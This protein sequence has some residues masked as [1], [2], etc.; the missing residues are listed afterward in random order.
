[1]LKLIGKNLLQLHAIQQI[2]TNGIFSFS[3]P[4]YSAVAVAFPS[5]LSTVA[6]AYLVAPYWDDVDIRL[7]GNISYEVHSRSSN[8]PGSSQLLDQISQFVED[9]TGDSFQG[10]WML[11][12]EWEE[13]H[14]WPHGFDIPIFQIFFPELVLVS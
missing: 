11:I 9:S 6:N 14:P 7:A 3:A 10:D 1:M 4:F 8:N 2:G 12:A 5:S 13:V